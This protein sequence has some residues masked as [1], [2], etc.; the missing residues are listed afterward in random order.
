M[1]TAED[2]MNKAHEVLKDKDEFL[3]DDTLRI[4]L[5]AALAAI[6]LDAVTVERCAQV[7]DE[8][9][10][11]WSRGNVRTQERME[12][13]YCALLLRALPAAPPF[14]EPLREAPMHGTKV[15]VADPSDPEFAGAAI[16]NESKMGRNLLIRGLCHAT[17]EPAAAH[18]RYLASLSAKTEGWA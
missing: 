13:K 8:R 9:S 3:S 6:P 1:I 18:G 2:I 5:E 16:W 15:W 7:L 10:L 4:A 11:F 12:V 14:P 17:K